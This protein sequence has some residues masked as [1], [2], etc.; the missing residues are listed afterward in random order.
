MPLT[1]FSAIDVNQKGYICHTLDEE[2]SYKSDIF[3][4]IYFEDK[5]YYFF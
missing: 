3:M 1:A 2:H 4:A 5:H